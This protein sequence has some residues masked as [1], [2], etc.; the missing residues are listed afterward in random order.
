MAARQRAFRRF[1]SAAGAALF[2][3]GMFILYGNLAVAVAG[4]NRILGNGSAALG[5]LPATAL[6]VSQAVHELDYPR[7]LHLLF[8][9][10]LLSFWPLLLVIF[11]TVLSS[12]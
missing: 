5:L 1:K 9:Q 4:L 3:L 6:A 2:I 12:D 8:Q 7:C 10:I 11:G